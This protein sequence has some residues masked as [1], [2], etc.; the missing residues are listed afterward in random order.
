MALAKAKKDRALRDAHLPAA[1]D[2][3]DRVLARSSSS[4]LV[5]WRQSG[6]GRVVLAKFVNTIVA[7]TGSGRNARQIGTLPTGVKLP[8]NFVYFPAPLRNVGI[9]VKV[10]VDSGG[11]PNGIP[12]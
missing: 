11:K 6:N 12:E 8:F 9:P 1:T 5:G 2:G 3:L 4:L 10:N 7:G